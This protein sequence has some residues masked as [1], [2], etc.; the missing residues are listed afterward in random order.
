MGETPRWGGP[1]VPLINAKPVL[2]PYFLTLL[3]SVGHGAVPAECEV[4]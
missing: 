1:Q 4:P 2:A 3:L